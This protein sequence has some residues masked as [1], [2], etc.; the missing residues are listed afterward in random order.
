MVPEGSLQ[1]NVPNAQVLT[2]F[3]VG[4]L[5]IPAQGAGT[6]IVPGTLELENIF[7]T[8][9]FAAGGAIQL[10]YGTGVTNPASA[11]IAATFLTSPTANQII[12]VGGL[13]G[14]TLSSAVLNTGIYLTAATADFTTGGGS[15]RGRLSYRV[16]TGF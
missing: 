13:L 9:A 16:D 7:G 4:T 5:L 15:L 6:L 8:A 1:F 2:L 12:R 14:S 10:S 3:S 11:T